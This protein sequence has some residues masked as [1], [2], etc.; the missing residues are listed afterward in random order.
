MWGFLRRG[1]VFAVFFVLVAEVFFRAVIPASHPPFQTYDAQYGI[2][3]QEGSPARS[4][5]FTVGRLARERTLWR[6]NDAGWNNTREYVG[7]TARN[8]PC[9]AVIGNSFVEGFYADVDSGLTSAL[10]RQLAP[11]VVVYNFG[12][13]G[14]S[15]AQML[16]VAQYA[17]A[18]FAPETY[19]FVINHHSLRSAVRNFGFQI[20]NE[21]YLWEDGSPKLI[22]PTVYHANRL[23]RLH[24]Y[25]ALVRYMYHN[26]AVL[27]TRAA[28]RQEAIQ[29]NDA[30][31]TKEL[32]DETPI[33]LATARDITR[34]ARA[35][36]PGAR[37]LFVIDG[38]RRRM[39]EDKARP[40]PLGESPLWATACREAGVE[41]LDLT[42]AF[43]VSFQH[44]GRRLD[45]PSN[46][47]WNQHG[48]AVV[49]KEIAG[50]IRTPA[51]AVAGM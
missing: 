42:D 35:E 13:S 31:A 8:R 45:L 39:Y 32:A 10:E 5:Q 14:V 38:D 47:H 9:I 27:T 43:W 4:G 51:P 48:M 50:V 21:Q 33:L 37:I 28:I 2:L 3:R 7:R 46:Y 16:R 34:R 25:S 20:F 24:T 23:M 11:D 19:V 18:E 29:R 36:H 30:S 49:A 22:P 41:F 17:E 40:E 6:V 26:A 12:K 15:A 44:D 1:A